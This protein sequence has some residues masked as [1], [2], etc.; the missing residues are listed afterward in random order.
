MV[1]KAV[2]FKTNQ[3]LWHE[4]SSLCFCTNR[5]CSALSN[6]TSRSSRSY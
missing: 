4:E 5:L 6:H 3:W 1:N 2:E